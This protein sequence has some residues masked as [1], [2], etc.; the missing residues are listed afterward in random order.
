MAT[1]VPGDGTS[2]SFWGLQVTVGPPSPPEKGALDTLEGVSSS[3][4]GFP[5]GARPL[6]GPGMLTLVLTLGHEGDFVGHRGDVSCLA[7]PC[8]SLPSA[9]DHPAGGRAS[10]PSWLKLGQ[11]FV[12]LVV[13]PQS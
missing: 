3:S 4:R 1:S 2:C 13:R 6:A 9:E 11:R 12:V 8:Q 10:S 5:T 7:V